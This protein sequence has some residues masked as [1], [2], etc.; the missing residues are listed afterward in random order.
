MKILKCNIFSYSIISCRFILKYYRNKINSNSFLKPYLKNYSISTHRYE[1]DA[2]RVSTLVGGFLEA[3]TEQKLAKT[4]LENLFLGGALTPLF[5]EFCD[6]YNYSNHQL[7]QLINYQYNEPE[8]PKVELFTTL[9]K[10]LRNRKNES[11]CLEQHI[12]HIVDI[13]II[14]K[15]QKTST[16]FSLIKEITFKKGGYSMLAYASCTNLVLTEIQNTVLYNFGSF[17]Q[18]LDDIFDVGQDIKEG[19]NTLVTTNILDIDQ[20]IAEFYQLIS[21]NCEE[22]EKLC[23]SRYNKLRIYQIYTLLA[24][25]ALSYLNTLKKASMKN[26]LVL[27]SNKLN[28]KYIW[29]SWNIR[30]TTDL[31]KYLVFN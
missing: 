10:L 14:S 29:R 9:L 13:Q 18:L 23:S 31:I 17:I 7:G 26:S 4:D 25:P 5:D 11:S 19:N 1:F 22:I 6:K 20:V 27:P 12:R 3:I 8:N 30:T 28:Q 2:I 15:F 16:D 24:I 21:K